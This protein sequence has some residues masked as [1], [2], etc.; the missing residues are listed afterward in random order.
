MRGVTSY[1]YLNETVQL[2]TSIA[3]ALPGCWQGFRAVST[4]GPRTRRKCISPTPIPRSASQRQPK[5]V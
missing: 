1:S 2:A 3:A 5:K 4:A